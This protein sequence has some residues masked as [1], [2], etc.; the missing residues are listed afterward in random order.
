MAAKRL[1]ID[2]TYRLKVACAMSEERRI[3]RMLA[4]KIPPSPI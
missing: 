2:T 3:R 4:E 1:Y